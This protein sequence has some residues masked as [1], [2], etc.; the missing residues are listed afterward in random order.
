[1]NMYETILKE[2]GTIISYN[3]N[4]TSLSAFQCNPTGGSYRTHVSSSRPPK[5][6]RPDTVNTMSGN[7]FVDARHVP[8]AALDKA[9]GSPAAAIGSMKHNAT[10]DPDTNYLQLVEV[11]VQVGEK[12]NATGYKFEPTE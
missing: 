6:I 11:E 7:I 12:E 3:G 4:G 9:F 10:K 5:N 2:G 1:M 8:R